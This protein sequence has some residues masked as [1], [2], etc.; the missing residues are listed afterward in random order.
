MTFHM[1]TRMNQR[2]ITGDL[3]SLTLEHGEWQG[4]RCR[5][6][7]KGLKRLIAE[8]DQI[9]ATALRALDKGGIVV[10]EADGNQIT[11]FP[12]TKHRG[13]RH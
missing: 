8:I 1:D 9:R 4:D 11:T 3:V 2:G 6:D 10:V 12:I 5:L 7:R 13:A